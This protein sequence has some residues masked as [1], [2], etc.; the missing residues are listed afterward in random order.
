[1]NR[2]DAYVVEIIKKPFI[3]NNKWCVEVKFE[4]FKI[5]K[6]ELNFQTKEDAEKVKIGFEFKY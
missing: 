5:F 3:K 6:T 4:C 2:L 1:M